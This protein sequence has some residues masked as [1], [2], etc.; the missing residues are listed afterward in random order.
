MTSTDLI[1]RLRSQQAW[2]NRGLLDACRPL[3][4]E[5]LA[6]PF[7]IGQGDVM[8]TITHLYAAEFVWLEAIDGK[9]ESVS[10]FTMRFNTVVDLESAWA[11]LDARW[12][13]FYDRLTGAEL[14]RPVTKISTSSGQGLTF[15]TPLADVLLHVFTHAQYTA[16]Q[17]KNMLRHLGVSPLPDVMLITQ[18]RGLAR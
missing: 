9:P 13:L 7:P 10:P 6:R 8:K 11:A 14:D 16:A 18:S 1:R 12:S 4:P 2:A 17:L 15:V 5:Q 3:S